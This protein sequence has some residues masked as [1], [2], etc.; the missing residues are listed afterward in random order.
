M[1]GSEEGYRV[2]VP[3][4]WMWAWREADHHLREQWG[5]G[6]MYEGVKK[7]DLIKKR[8]ENRTDKCLVVSNKAE[9]TTDTCNSM[10]ESLVS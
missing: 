8:M 4:T 9:Q 2:D 1:E 3:A 7:A 10:S 5:R 6:C